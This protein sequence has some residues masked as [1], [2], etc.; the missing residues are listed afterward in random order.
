[1]T[2]DRCTEDPLAW[3]DVCGNELKEQEAELGLE[4]VF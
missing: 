1:M 2:G 3:S 4:V